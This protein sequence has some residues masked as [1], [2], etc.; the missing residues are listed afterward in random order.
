LLPASL[1]GLTGIQQIAS[2]KVMES[3]TLSF[4]QKSLT[5]QGY[6]YTPADL[7]ELD[8]GLRFTPTV[9]M[10]LAIY[11]LVTQQAAVHFVLAAIGILPFWF[12]A[13]H[14]FDRFYNFALRPLWG[15]VALPPNPLPRRIACFIGG[16]MN[17]GIGVSFLAG[18]PF[19]AYIFGATL[20][21]LQLI[22]ISTHFCVASWMYEGLLRLMGH[23]TA[24]ISNEQAKRLLGGGAVLIDVRSPVEF[25]RG[26]LHDAVNM[27]LDTLTQHLRSLEGKTAILYCQSG[28]RCQQAT[29][30]LKRKCEGSFYNFGAMSR[31][32]E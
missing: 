28:M 22:V 26:H 27:P 4:Q 8:W 19:L 24:P 14:P 16:A 1:I 10:A 31:W 21:P 6:D 9:C 18:S 23:W 17:V 2:G 12:P 13:S 3:S 30:T 25:A 32:Q 15:G 7:K 11:G 29:Q 5:Q 20:I